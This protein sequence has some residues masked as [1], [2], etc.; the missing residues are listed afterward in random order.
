ML[1]LFGFAPDGVYPARSVTIAAVR[2]YRTLSAFL[3]CFS[4]AKNHSSSFLSVALSLSL[5]WPGVTRHPAFVEPG[6]SSNN[7]TEICTTRDR[8]AL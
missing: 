5:R 6:L 2:S 4:Q 8:P 7:D 3:L 1:S